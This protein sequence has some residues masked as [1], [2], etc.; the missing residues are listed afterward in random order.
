M[1]I[2]FYTLYLNFK[3]FIFRIMK[4]LTMHSFNISYIYTILKELH[5]IFVLIQIS[6]IQLPFEYIPFL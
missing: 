4:N 1:S 2:L 5:C 6:L 3:K